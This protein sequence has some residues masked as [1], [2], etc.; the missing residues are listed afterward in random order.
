MIKL[1]SSQIQR[2]TNNRRK[3]FLTASPL[4]L[5]MNYLLI[6]ELSSRRMIRM[7]MVNDNYQDRSRLSQNTVPIAEV[8]LVKTIVL[9]LL[10]LILIQQVNVRINHLLDLLVVSSNCFNIKVFQFF[11]FFFFVF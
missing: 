1:T 7:E 6:D 4:F 10:D 8:V 11:F 3:V 5:L 9:L 2:P